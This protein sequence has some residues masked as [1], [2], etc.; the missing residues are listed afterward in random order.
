MFAINHAATAL[1]IKKKYQ[2]VPMVWLLISV[3]F[4]EILWV[5]FN[6]LG[7]EQTTTEDVVRYVGDVHLSFMPY[8]HSIATMLGV[9]LLAWLII[10]KGFG[11]PLI[12]IA[13]GIGIASHLF[14]DLVTHSSDIVI[15]PLVEE[16]KFGL[17]LYASFP[18]VAFLFELVYGIACWWIY[19]GS[20]GLLVV[21]VL[22]N[23]ANLSMFFT[24]ISGLEAVMANRPILLTTVILVQIVVTL[25]L[26]GVYSK[27]QKGMSTKN[28]S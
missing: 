27:K 7:I 2:D 24:A 9:A 25:V 1:I 10:A 20:K 6:Y 3:Q 19:K 11:K 22:F 8:S 14:L 16:P 28:A 15:A 5:L 21:I 4:M 17:G 12:G 18:A 13:V 23:L 26:V